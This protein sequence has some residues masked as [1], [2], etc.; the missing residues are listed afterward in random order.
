MTYSPDTR[1][2]GLPA[3]GWMNCFQCQRMCSPQDPCACCAELQL[4]S[5][6]TVSGAKEAED[7]SVQVMLDNSTVIPARDQRPGG[8]T[9]EVRSVSDGDIGVSGES[10]G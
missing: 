7:D 3:G 5:G 2:H 4:A 8:A 10:H 6:G 9:P 1:T